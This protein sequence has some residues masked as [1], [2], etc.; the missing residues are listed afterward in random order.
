MVQDAAWSKAPFDFKRDG[1]A[2]F[3]LGLNHLPSC[4][5]MRTNRATT[6]GPDLR[7][8]SAGSNFGRLNTCGG[9]WRGRGWITLRALPL[10]AATGHVFVADILDA[11]SGAPTSAPS[12]TT[13]TARCPEGFRLR[14]DLSRTP[15]ASH[16]RS[17]RGAPG[18]G[19]CRAIAPGSC[20]LP[21][22]WVASTKLLQ[23]SGKR[24]PAPVCR[25]WGRADRTRQPRRFATG[26]RVERRRRRPLDKE[27]RHLTGPPAPRVDLPRVVE[28]MARSH[29]TSVPRRRGKPPPSNTFI[30]PTGDAE[31]YFLCT[32]DNSPLALTADFRGHGQ[33]ARAVE[34]GNG[35]NHTPARVSRTPADAPGSILAFEPA[36][37]MCSSIFRKQAPATFTLVPP[38]RPDERPSYA[39]RDFVTDATGALWSATLAPKVAPSPIAI[40]AGLEGHVSTA[41]GRSLHAGFRRAAWMAGRQ[42]RSR[43]LLLRYGDLS[44]DVS[45]AGG[46]AAQ[47]SPGHARSRGCLRCRPGATQRPARRRL[48]ETAIC[49]RSHHP[50][51]TRSGTPSEI[52]VA[53]KWTNRLMG[54]NLLPPDADFQTKIQQ[55]PAHL[56]AAGG[57]FPIGYSDPAKLRTSGRRTSFGSYNPFFKPPA[58]RFPRS[59]QVSS[60]PS[61]ASASSGSWHRKS[62][63]TLLARS[64][65]RFSVLRATGTG[66]G[67]SACA[68]PAAWSSRRGRRTKK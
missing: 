67:R 2:A 26:R 46:E 37:S 55:Q 52:T 58:R 22:T 21:K 14:P 63:P 13:P 16:G 23:Q 60:A 65:K 10:L 50:P 1:D 36:G 57:S 59:F 31:I 25:L 41:D 61:P 3:A 6:C 48:V 19:P 9:R 54:D 66:R 47:G 11:T 51:A 53:N 24:W 7:S 39:G 35:R 49:R 12:S 68:K 4:I 34:S 45:D 28:K 5:N 38:V 18:H 42:G 29:R 30:A 56:W 44:N 40:T 15:A 33:T 27:V 62:N 64:H 17:R 8:D 43:P 20:R 32:A